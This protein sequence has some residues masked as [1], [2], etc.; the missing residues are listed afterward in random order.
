VEK[1]GR[2]VAQAEHTIYVSAERVEVLTR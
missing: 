1:S 2:K